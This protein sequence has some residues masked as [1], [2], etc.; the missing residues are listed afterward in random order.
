M[1][2]STKEKYDQYCA[3]HEQNPEEDEDAYWFEL[4][5]ELLDLE[6]VSSLYKFVKQKPSR[7]SKYEKSF[8][9]DGDL[10]EFLVSQTQ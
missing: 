7:N 4:V 10:Q 2:S 6:T 1:N 8:L 3:K 9:G 5:Y